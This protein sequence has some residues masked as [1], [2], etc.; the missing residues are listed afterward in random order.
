MRVVT[1]SN[2][3]T[4]QVEHSRARRQRAFQL[5]HDGWQR[6][7]D[8]RSE[9]ISRSRLEMQDAWRTGRLGRLVAAAVRWAAQRLSS[10]PA[11]PQPMHASDEEARFDAGQ[12]GENHVAW[13]IAELF[14]DEWVMLRGYMTRAG[15]NDLL[16]IGPAGIIAV[17]VKSVAGTVHVR[18]GVWTRDKY[19]RFD[20]LVER[21]LPIQDA[22]G[23]SPSQQVNAVA[24]ALEQRLRVNKVQVPVR[25][26]V[27]L[28]HAKSMLGVV[29]HPGV[30]L[31][32]LAHDQDLYQRL[33]ELVS[34]GSG[35]RVVDVA[36]VEDIVRRDHEYQTA[37]RMKRKPQAASSIQSPSETKAAVAIVPTSSMRPDDAAARASSDQFRPS[38]KLPTYHAPSE[39]EARQARTLGQDLTR[40]VL[41]RTNADPAFEWE[42]RRKVSGHLQAGGTRVLKMAVDPVG[43]PD[44]SALLKRLIA[45][46]RESV[47]LDDRVLTALVVPIAWRWTARE[48]GAGANALVTQADRNWLNTV[49]FDIRVQLRADGVWFSSHAY[50]GGRL[51]ALD[52]RLLHEALRRMEQKLEP[53][54][55][56]LLPLELRPRS[57]PSWEVFYALAVV[58]SDPDATLEVNSEHVQ[59][60]LER[61]LDGVAGAFELP[62]S[63][64]SKSNDAVQVSAE[65]VWTLA[66]GVR[67]GRQLALRHLLE[68][69]FAS[70][71]QRTGRMEC[72]FTVDKMLRVH[73]LVCGSTTV[74][75]QSYPLHTEEHP[76]AVFSQAL[77]QA[78]AARVPRELDVHVNEVD[79]YD[80]RQHA[81]AHGLTW[82]G[83]P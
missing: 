60:S 30:D 73:L 58:A 66:Q 51:L 75:E 40:L 27:I 65:G 82:I 41:D 69:M 10:V 33:V 81:R 45:E 79:A 62:A 7:V 8:R 52:A 28:A 14:N 38:A 2:H 23:R 74:A 43:A 15:E 29:A 56:E 39:L 83:R 31:L 26:A 76:A 20:N 50:E 21:D 54:I 34:A 16:M 78:I 44:E 67:H 71:S 64:A 22:S 80:Y 61:S 9:A 19:D 55:S 12:A 4:E 25:R 49:A 35:Q 47:V 46:C 42:V 70:H 53:E 13:R 68:A 72:W 37:R 18:D 59:R 32:A 48:D 17:E 24:D 3:A 63:L 57:V 77:S 1:L 5:V 36:L 11:E 6:Q